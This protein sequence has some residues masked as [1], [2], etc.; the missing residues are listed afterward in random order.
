MGEKKKYPTLDLSDLKIRKK[1]LTQSRGDAVYYSYWW[2]K[3]KIK[4]I[5]NHVIR[6]DYYWK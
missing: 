3:P 5:E 6:M 4:G 2:P 1:Q